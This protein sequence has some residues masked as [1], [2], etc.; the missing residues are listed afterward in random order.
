VLAAGYFL[1]KIQAIDFKQF[2]KVGTASA[3]SMA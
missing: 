1:T 3:I 2:F